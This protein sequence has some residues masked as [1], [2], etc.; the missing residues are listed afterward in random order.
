MEHLHPPL[1]LRIL[2]FILVLAVLTTSFTFLAM[3][4][5]P[6]TQ[7]SQ[8]IPM[9]TI[10]LDAGHGG[11]DGGAVSASGLIEKDVNL[12]LTLMLRDLLVANGVKVVLTRESD[13]LLYDKNADYHGR[14][15]ALDL[16]A[17]KKIAEE[18]PNS[19]FV[20]IHMNTYPLPTCQGLQVWY[21]PNNP[22]S[23]KIAE[24]VQSTTRALLQQKND[25]TVK[26][27]GSSIYLL[28]HINTP[29]I[30]VECGFLS[31]PQEA[32]RLADENYLKELAFTLFIS[33][34]QAE[35]QMTV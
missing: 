7:P 24:Q 34:M 31:S 17:R 11:E 4:Y 33:I 16:A 1:L 32:E 35:K 18:T 30:L 28:H 13:T 25:R 6:L 20:S 3:R 19:I 9:R 14:K 26:K 29:A 5:L 2:L 10:V 27:A 12:R 15:K 22:S 21:S 23:Q 8:A